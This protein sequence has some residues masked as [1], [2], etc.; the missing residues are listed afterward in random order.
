MPPKAE[1]TVEKTVEK[2]DKA[3]KAVAVIDPKVAAARER[4]LEAAISVVSIFCFPGYV[5]DS[6]NNTTILSGALLLNCELSDR[7]LANIE[8]NRR[9]RRHLTQKHADFTPGDL[10]SFQFRHRFHSMFAR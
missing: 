5:S 3:E 1:K 9:C 10:A 8:Q 6:S 2:A 7:T 4:D